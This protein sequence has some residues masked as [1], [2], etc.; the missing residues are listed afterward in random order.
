MH[1]LLYTKISQFDSL[2]SKS[3]NFMSAFKVY[4]IV[5]LLFTHFKIHLKEVAQHASFLCFLNLHLYY[6]CSL[7][8]YLRAIHTIIQHT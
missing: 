1:R 3:K 7:N 2:L 8:Q 4:K 6:L 5:T